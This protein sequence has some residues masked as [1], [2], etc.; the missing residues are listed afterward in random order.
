[1]EGPS[2]RGHPSLTLISVL[3]AIPGMYSSGA[4]RASANLGIMYIPFRPTGAGEAAEVHV[5]Y[6]PDG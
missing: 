6:S 3:L 4:H 1:M 5:A 2:T